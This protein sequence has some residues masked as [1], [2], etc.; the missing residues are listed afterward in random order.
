M[1]SN[2]AT[3]GRDNLAQERLDVSADIVL[4]LV[5]TI[6][7]CGSVDPIMI[8][9]PTIGK[10]NQDLGYAAI[11]RSC[12]LQGL[13]NQPV[14]SHET[15]HLLSIE[16]HDSDPAENLPVGFSANHAEEDIFDNVTVG[17]G[18]NDCILGC[19]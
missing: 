16:H 14:A 12:F 9:R 19:D 2:V 3:K 1:R 10:E 5:P 8:N 6:G 17:A 7:I 4:M 11:G 13:D 15:S 18:K